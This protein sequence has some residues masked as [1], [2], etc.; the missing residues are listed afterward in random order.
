[1]A[2]PEGSRG[3][4]ARV[5][6]ALAALGLGFMIVELVALHRLVLLVGHPVITSA[7]ISTTRVRIP[8]AAG[9]APSP[10]KRIAIRVTGG[11]HH[12]ESS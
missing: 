11:R 1:M 2:V 7:K 9:M 12:L 4:G 3:R 5:A 6:W 10:P 8:A